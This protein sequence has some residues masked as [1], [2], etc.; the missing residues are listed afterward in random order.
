[1]SSGSAYFIYR[2]HTAKF[3]PTLLWENLSPLEWLLRKCG[4]R[5]AHADGQPG[6]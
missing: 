5:L 4:A 1:M 3:V 2:P 6:W